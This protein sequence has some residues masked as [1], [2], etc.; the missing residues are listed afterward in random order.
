MAGILTEEENATHPS[1]D[2]D[3]HHRQSYD[4]FATDRMNRNEGGE[5][6]DEEEQD[7]ED[8]DENDSYVDDESDVNSSAKKRRKSSSS[9]L[10]DITFTS[11]K[12]GRSL[13]G[14]GSVIETPPPQT[15]KTSKVI[16]EVDSVSTSSFDDEEGVVE[17]KN[18]KNKRPTRRVK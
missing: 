6:V 18:P 5:V 16:S 1:T 9:T 13:R 10:S 2:D 11:P 14:K 4:T 17:T 8:E 3:H 15:K 12:G 7:E